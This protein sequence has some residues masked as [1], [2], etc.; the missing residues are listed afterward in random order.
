MSNIVW[1]DDEDIF[2]FDSL[3]ELIDSTEPSAGKI[4]W[5]GTASPVDPQ[6]IDCDYIIDEIGNRASDEYGDI[7]YHYPDVSAD[8]KKELDDFL[9][10]WQDKH[11]STSSF[12]KVNDSKEYVITEKDL[13]EARGNK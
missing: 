9:R 11:C 1:S 4:V 13:D 5:F 10:A 12:W 3:S 8:G 6:W 7:A 2:N